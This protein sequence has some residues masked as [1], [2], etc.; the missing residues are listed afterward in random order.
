MAKEVEFYFDIVSP[1]SYLAW[2]QMPKLVEETGATIIYRPFFLPGLFKA[3]GSSSPITVPTKGRWLFHDLRRFAKKYDVPFWMNDNFPLNSLYIM[4]GLVGWQDKP[5]IEALGNGFFQA[6]WADNK[7]V[8]DP[9][10]MAGIVS[11]AG[12]DPKEWQATL[13]DEDI[14]QSIFDISDALAKRGAFGAPT[15]FVKRGGKEE[16]HWGQ[17]RLEFVKEALLDA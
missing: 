16:M 10:I 7:N 13:S 17:D 12:V 8:N 2:T 6:M 14:K 11:A 15:F 1:A 9:E 5:E 4:R 3:A